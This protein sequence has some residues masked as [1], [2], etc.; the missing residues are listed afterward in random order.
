MKLGDAMALERARE[1]HNQ[2]PLNDL[3]VLP[4]N[5]NVRR[6]NPSGSAQ[7]CSRVYPADC[8]GW[9]GNCSDIATFVVLENGEPF[10]YV[11]E[12]HRKD[13]GPEVK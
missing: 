12:R 6:L 7:L 3:K 10:A 1:Q 4:A 5:S 13:L 9:R 2:R 11:C 8:Q